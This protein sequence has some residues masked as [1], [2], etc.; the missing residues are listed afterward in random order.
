MLNTQTLTIDRNNTIKIKGY[1]QTLYSILDENNKQVAWFD[2]DSWFNYTKYRE[3]YELSPRIHGGVILISSSL[4]GVGEYANALIVDTTMFNCTV[5]GRKTAKTKIYLCDMM[6]TVIEDE[7][8]TFSKFKRPSLIK[9]SVIA[10]GDEEPTSLVCIRNSYIDSCTIN[11]DNEDT[12]TDEQRYCFNIRECYLKNFT[13]SDCQKGMLSNS[14]LIGT[15]ISA[16]IVEMQRSVVFC[17]PITFSSRLRLVNARIKHIRHFIELNTAKG[18]LTYAYRADEKKKDYVIVYCDIKD[19][20]NPVINL[21]VGPIK[22]AQWINSTEQDKEVR[23]AVLEN[24]R[25]IYG[26]MNLYLQIH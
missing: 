25:Y 19:R 10:A 9:N 17:V 4:I 16:P 26:Y 20:Y 24:G 5:K 18:P 23:T 14:S 8:L 15:S 21:L 13:F 2:Q 22:Y 6:D 1:D 11:I 3:E 12:G 7:V